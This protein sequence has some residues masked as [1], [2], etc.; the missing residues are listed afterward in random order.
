MPQTID[1]RLEPAAAQVGEQSHGREHAMVGSH[2]M[3]AEV[4]EQS[5]ADKGENNE[6]RDDDPESEEKKC[7]FTLV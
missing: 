3:V 2:A 5:Q 4:G 1:T 7:V 6:H